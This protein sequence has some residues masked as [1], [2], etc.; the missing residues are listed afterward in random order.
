VTPGS[1]GDSLRTRRIRAGLTQEAV[2][3]RAGVSVRTLRE[4]ELDRAARPRL[5]SLR[6]L[7]TA[8]GLDPEAV[9]WR[10]G[11]E[12]DVLGALRVRVGERTVPAGTLKQRYLLALLALH[13][14]DAVR[15][16]EII[17]V[18]WGEDPPASCR[19]L[20]HI[21]VSRLRRLLHADVLVAEYGGYRLAVQKMRLDL[22]LFDELAGQAERARSADPAAA[23]HLMERA[24]SCWQGPV[25]TDLTSR[26]HQHP[27]AEAARQRRLTVL[28][29]HAELAFER[30]AYESATR[31]LR[32]VANEEP[33]HEGV[34]AQLMLALA[35]S[36]QRAAA[37]TI[38]TRIGGR[39]R[40]D[41]G[42]APGA[43]LREA[44]HRILRG[45]GF[46]PVRES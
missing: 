8:V 37:L 9:I 22:A 16:E 31:Q 18:L 21:Y 33:L 29:A 13:A 10:T 17:D 6:R 28:H 3:R 2:S 12:V 23:L 46:E 11:V 38:F 42:V 41:L 36:G 1:L 40:A 26:L 34:H 32:V 24:L 45:Q 35:G 27:A 20:V 5:T 30:G 25:L 14:G 4:I 39:L 43:Q 7:A 15:R 44:H 19:N